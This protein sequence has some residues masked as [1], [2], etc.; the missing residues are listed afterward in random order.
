MNRR[1]FLGTAALGLLPRPRAV[2]AQA[3]PRVARIGIL[4]LNPT[5]EIAGPAP[6]SPATAAF[7][8]GMRDL[9]Y[10]HGEH[11]VTEAR[12]AS[13]RPERFPE[14]IAELIELRVDLI[15]ATGPS[16]PALKQAGPSL[17]V[18]MSAS[19]DPLALGL[20][21]SLG[22]PGGNFTGLSLQSV[23]TT[24]KRL[25]LLRE[26][27]PGTAAVGVIWNQASILNW[28]AAEVAAPQ[29]R[30]KAVS[31]EIHDAAEV[32]AAFKA[33]GRA[34][35]GA[36]IVFA[37]GLLFPNA[38]RVAEAA[39]RSRLPAMY[40]LRTYAEAGGLVSYGADINDIWR[41]AAG[42][43][44]RILKGTRPGDLPIEQP[45]EFELV[46]N[47]KTART[48]GLTLPQSLLVRADE[49]LQ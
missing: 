37:A 4:G 28:R 44:D 7:I 42:Y 43:V 48:L 14:L 25:E 41:R 36:V 10:V 1:A 12:G 13:A 20:V 35:A 34:G 47:L 22:R 26:I 2:A 6:R 9:G 29:Q 15:I 31:L 8:R 49:V 11:Y 45:S 39:A 17:P 5:S 16:L 19:P 3:R 24:G 32:D 38:R 23:E 18:I 30:W 27:V 33:A 46:I 21:Q 40:E